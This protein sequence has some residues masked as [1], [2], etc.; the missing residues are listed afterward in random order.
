M[1]GPRTDLQRTYNGLTLEE[2]K[3]SRRISLKPVLSLEE[4]FGMFSTFYIVFQ[5]YR[6]RCLILKLVYTFLKLIKSMKMK[7][8]TFFKKED[9]ISI[10]TEY[11]TTDASAKEICL[12][13]GLSSH[14]VLCNWV[15]R[16][17]K[18]AENAQNLLPLP[19]KS[20][21][22]IIPGLPSDMAKTGKDPKELEARIAELEKALKWEQMRT[23]A[24][25]TMIEIAEEQGMKVRKKSGVK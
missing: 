22:D 2:V 13:Y 12:K 10:A 6:T 1:N 17:I 18:N 14:V 9:R 24:L 4:G 19:R 3:S 20:V 15:K 8:R 25:E 23:H 5:A 16:Y 11:Y 21:S 7:Q